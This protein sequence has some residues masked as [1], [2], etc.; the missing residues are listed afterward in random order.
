MAL[1][2]RG[3]WRATCGVDLGPE[4]GGHGG[5]AVEFRIAG[6]ARGP[7]SCIPGSVAHAIGPG[8]GLA[9]PAMTV[10]L[11]LVPQLFDTWAGAE[12]AGVIRGRAGPKGS[13]AGWAEAAG[14]VPESFAGAVW[15]APSGRRQRSCRPR[16]RSWLF[17][18]ACSSSAFAGLF[19]SWQLSTFNSV[20]LRGIPGLVHHHI[21]RFGPW[22]HVC[23]DGT[24]LGWTAFPGRR[25]GAPSNAAPRVRCG[26]GEPK[27]L[28]FPGLSDASGRESI[29]RV[30]ARQHQL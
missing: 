6:V 25:Q 19:Y 9:R 18:A 17:F 28:S 12:G 24:H 22:L 15:Q 16:Q 3:P 4:G 14:P 8:P 20:G 26:V 13:A 1:F 7:T 23:L 29:R 10:G 21:S 30:R 27:G 11:P 2:R 5:H